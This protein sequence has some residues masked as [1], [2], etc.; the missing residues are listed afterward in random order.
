[1]NKYAILLCLLGISQTAFSQKQQPGDYIHVFTGTSNSRWMIFPGAALPFGMVKLSPDNQDNVWNGGYEYT[2]ASISGF[3]HLHGMSLS[4]VSYMP[5]VGHLF[6]GEEY[7]KL[8]PGDT[9]GPFGSMWTAG[10][11]SRFKK[12]TEKARAGYYQVHL[13]DY[14]IH[15]ELTA[16][17]T[18]E[19]IYYDQV[20]FSPIPAPS[21][22][23]G[24][25]SMGLM[26]ALGCAWR[27]WRNR[28]FKT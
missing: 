9:D 3:S 25:V 24:L 16:T 21:T 7:A 8:Y 26:A 15:V 6:F 28:R 13:Y 22:L 27:R 5:A 12:E 20:Y 11:R 2:N 10:Y 4:G 14:D 1:M 23:V 17:T 19:A 18:Q